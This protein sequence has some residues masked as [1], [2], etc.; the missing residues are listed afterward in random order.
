MREDGMPMRRNHWTRAAFLIGTVA[1]GPFLGTIPAVGNGAG[2]DSLIVSLQR[3]VDDRN[4]VVQLIRTSLPAPDGIPVRLQILEIHP[5]GGNTAP[6][7][8][9]DT[10]VVVPWNPLQADFR[11]KGPPAG[12]KPSR[13]LWKAWLEPALVFG[14]LTGLAY[15][16]YSVRSH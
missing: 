11:T 9:A 1:C 7:A 15:S 14:V 4:M 16:L 5:S 3:Q 6:D 8:V 10:T 2:G 13:P 12:T